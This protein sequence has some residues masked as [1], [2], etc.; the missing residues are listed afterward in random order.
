MLRKHCALYIRALRLLLGVFCFNS[1]GFVEWHFKPNS[2]LVFFLFF[3]LVLPSHPIYRFIF[4]YGVTLFLIFSLM[5]GASC[6]FLL[7]SLERWQMFQAMN[8]LLVSTIY[9]L[10]RGKMLRGCLILIESN[11]YSCKHL[12]SRRRWEKYFGLPYL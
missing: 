1:M 11:I 5:L 10:L 2:L 4:D 12:W 6:F 3:F 8:F 9:H 7:P